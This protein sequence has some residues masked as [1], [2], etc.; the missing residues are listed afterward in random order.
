MFADQLNKNLER[1]REIA[2]NLFL[3][4]EKI[5]NSIEKNRKKMTKFLLYQGMGSE[6]YE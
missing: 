3:F 4:E 5:I 6:Q 1:Q 2:F